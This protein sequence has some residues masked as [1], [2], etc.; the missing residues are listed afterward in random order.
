MH[1][2]IDDISYVLRDSAISG[3]EYR[4]VATNRGGNQEGCADPQKCEGTRNRPD[5]SRTVEG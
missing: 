1:I 4:H 3:V 5:N 2:Y